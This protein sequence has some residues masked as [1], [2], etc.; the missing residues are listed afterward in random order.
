MWNRFAMA[1]CIKGN[2]VN[3]VGTF[4]MKGVYTYTGQFKNGKGDGRGEVVHSNGSRYVGE[5]KE[6]KY[7]GQGIFYDAGDK[8]VGERK[9]GKI[10]GQG[11]Y[12][13]ADGD[14]Y[15]GEWKDGKLE[16]FGIG[17][18]WGG[19]ESLAIYQ[20]IKK[21]R[22]FYKLSNDEHLVRLHIGL[23]DPNDLIKDLKN[24][25]KRIK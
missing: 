12:T 2:C 6:D 15:V 3:G 19:F 25:L 13:Y 14:K 17:Y 8:Y 16:L 22:D 23:E 10:N 1:E 5:V 11:T 7:N 18:S 21:S 9:D 4:E 24:S 20:D